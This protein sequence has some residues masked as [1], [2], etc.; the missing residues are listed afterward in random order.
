MAIAEFDLS[1]LSWAVW[2]FAVPMLAGGL[3]YAA[4]HRALAHN[5]VAVLNLADWLS[6]GGDGPIRLVRA[7]QFGSDPA[8]KLQIFAPRQADSGDSLLP[9]VMFIH[10]GA[11]MSGD[12]CDYRFI[13]RTLAPHGTA[14]ALAGYRLLPEGRFPAM[15]EDGAAALRWLVD[16]AAQLGI[17]PARITVMGHSAGGYNALMLALDPRWLTGAGLPP[18]AIHRTI[19]LSAPTDFLPLDDPA[20]TAAFG[21]VADLPMTQPVNHAR[22]DAAPLLL[23][24]GADDRRVR[25]RNTRVLAAALADAGAPCRAVVLEQS[26]HEAPLKTLARPFVRDGRVLGEVLAFLGLGTPPASAGVHRTCP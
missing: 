25:P 17:D 3:G 13:A 23:L 9:L 21:H 5:P 6:R 19:A 20:S 8:Q 26:N 15:L 24:H 2:A 1:G 12:P 7:A 10:G 22:A 16:N 11:W 18:D 14:V 4:L